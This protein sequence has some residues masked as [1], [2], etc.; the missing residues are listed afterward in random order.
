MNR[1]NRENHPISLV[2]RGHRLINRVINQTIPLVV[3][4][5]A[6]RRSTI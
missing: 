2:L 6:L 5:D 4:F 3:G 1:V